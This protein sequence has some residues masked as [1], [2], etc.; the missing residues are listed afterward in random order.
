MRCSTSIA[1]YGLPV[2]PLTRLIE[3]RR[4]DLYQDPMPDIATFEGYA[5]E[6]VS[7]LYQLGAMI[8]NGGRPVETGDAAGHLGVAHAL[9]GHLRAFGY[10]ASQGRI[11]L[12]WDV[13]AVCGV[14]EGEVFAGQASEG[15]AVALTKLGEIA[16]RAS[17]Q[18]RG[19]DRRAAAAAAAGLR[20]DRRA[21]VAARR[22]DLE[23]PFQRPSDI[24]DWRKIARADA[25]GSCARGLGPGRDIGQRPVAHRLALGHRLVGAAPA[26]SAFGLLHRHR[27]QQAE[28]DVHRL[29]AARPGL[30]LGGEVAAEDVVEQRAERRRRRRRLERL[31]ARL[32]RGHAAGDQP[33]R[34]ALDIALDAGD[35]P[36]K[37]QPRLSLQP[38]L[39][40]Q[41]L[42]RIEEGVVVQPAEPGELRVL[43]AR[44]HAGRS[45][46]ACRI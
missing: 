19:R 28:I 13:F 12:P 40:V 44:D 41:H 9:I 11:F 23:S 36:G 22:L 45:R 25:G 38:K 1:E 32:G 18:G 24:A 14:K 37:A 5:G 46:P 43:E 42:R 6:T 34:G 27:R 16:A 29:E 17:A 15:L 10:N 4:F 30:A 8:L 21:E 33:D 39:A 3:A 7:A 20:A 31:A 2:P 26:A 35:L